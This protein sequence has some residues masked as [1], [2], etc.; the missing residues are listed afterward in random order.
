MVVSQYHLE[1]EYGRTRAAYES[2]MG[3]LQCLKRQGEHPLWV[4][5]EEKYRQRKLGMMQG[6]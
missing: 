3:R 4:S 2:S 1:H 6:I 5:R